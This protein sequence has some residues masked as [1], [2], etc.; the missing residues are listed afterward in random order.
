MAG[1]LC[2]GSSPTSLLSHCALAGSAP[3][4]WE[5]WTWH[6]LRCSGDAKPISGSLTISISHIISS[7]FWLKE[8]VWINFPHRTG[9]S[10]AVGRNLF[11][12]Y[13]HVWVQLTW[14]DLLQR[15]TQNEKIQFQILEQIEESHARKLCAAQKGRKVNNTMIS[16][17]LM[18][19][20]SLP[21]PPE[22]ELSQS[23]LVDG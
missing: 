15:A 8:S 16:T 20:S 13:N 5:I 21:L 9:L 22:S 14:M 17:D 1:A 23:L 11:T 10:V 4:L 18:M 6:D 7:F 2:P 3:W 19:L 12:R